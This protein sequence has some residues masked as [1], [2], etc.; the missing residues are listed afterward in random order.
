MS[1]STYAH[2]ENNNLWQQGLLLSQEFSQ[3]EGRQPRVLVGN[4]TKVSQQLIR[5]VCSALADMGFNVD[6]APVLS[7]FDELAT[8]CLENDADVLL[9]LGADHIT[10]TELTNLAKKM[11]LLKSETV[12]ALTFQGPESIMNQETLRAYYSIFP[13]DSD[14][15]QISLALLKI[16][17]SSN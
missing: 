13:E 11:S 9:I 1:D 15:V 12:K 14:P 10:R 6:V 8:Q 7:S 4:S 17:L 3:M 16:L 2:P 5:K